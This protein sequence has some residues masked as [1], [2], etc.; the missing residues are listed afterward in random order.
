VHEDVPSN[1]LT[2]VCHLGLKIGDVPREFGKPYSSDGRG[3]RRCS[4][5][6]ERLELSADLR[7]EREIRD[8]DRRSEGAP[9]G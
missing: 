1:Q 7:D 4:G 6:C 2:S 8:V 9:M 5:G 3:R